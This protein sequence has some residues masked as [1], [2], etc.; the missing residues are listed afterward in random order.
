MIQSLTSKLWQL[1]ARLLA[2]DIRLFRREAVGTMH[3]LTEGET[4]EDG[5]GRTRLATRAL[6]LR[7]AREDRKDVLDYCF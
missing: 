5:S 2:A 4:R 1:R 3:K 7:D 6:V